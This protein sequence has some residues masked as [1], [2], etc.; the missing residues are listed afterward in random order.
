MYIPSLHNKK[1][2]S[3]YSFFFV[4]TLRLAECVTFFIHVIAIIYIFL[5][6]HSLRL[7]FDDCPILV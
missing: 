3:Y 6:F 1:P 7:P 4:G 2:F 5:F